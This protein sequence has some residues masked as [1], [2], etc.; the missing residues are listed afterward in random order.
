MTITPTDYQ[1]SDPLIVF[2]LSWM[3]RRA[4]VPAEQHS[5][6]VVWRRISPAIFRLGRHRRRK[7]ERNA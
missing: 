3:I 2:M 5:L 1:A 4:T 7:P 6:F